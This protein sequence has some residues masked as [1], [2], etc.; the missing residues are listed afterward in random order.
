MS[1]GED[2]MSALAKNERVMLRLLE[3]CVFECH[4]LYK[5]TAVYSSFKRHNQCWNSLFSNGFV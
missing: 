5:G 1:S 4:D 3:E 2:P